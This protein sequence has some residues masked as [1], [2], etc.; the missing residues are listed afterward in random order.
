MMFERSLSEF[1][2]T[3]T[4]S[5]FSPLSAPCIR[6]SSARE[7]LPVPQLP[8]SRT[9]FALRDAAVQDGVEAIDAC[10]APVALPC[11]LRHDALRMRWTAYY[12]FFQAPARMAGTYTR[13]CA[14]SQYAARHVFM[15]VL[16]SFLP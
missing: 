15:T 9:V 10:D 13:A 2:V 7:V 4:N 14:P 11:P 16:R 6:N 12:C 3:D 1:S 8:V 5:E